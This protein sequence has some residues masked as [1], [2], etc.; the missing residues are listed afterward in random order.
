MGLANHT[1]LCRPKYEA[2]GCP[3]SILL[4]GVFGRSFP[5]YGSKDSHYGGTVALQWR[6]KLGAEGVAAPPPIFIRGWA[7]MSFSPPPQ[8]KMDHLLF[9]KPPN[10]DFGRT[11]FGQ[12]TWLNRYSIIFRLL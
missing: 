12:M 8:K 9:I 2:L 1:G 7:E 11:V 5:N 6:R 3:R 4:L 10:L